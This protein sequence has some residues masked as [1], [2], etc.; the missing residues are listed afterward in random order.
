VKV[1]P[2]TKVTCLPAHRDVDGTFPDQTV[3]FNMSMGNS[4]RWRR[5]GLINLAKMRS[6]ISAAAEDLNVIPR[7][8]DAVITTLSGGNQQKALLG[9]VVAD[10][11]GC[12]VLCEPT[13]GVDV[14]TRREIYAFVKKLA[15]D[16]CAV[17]V[18][19]SDMEDLAS[20]AD[21]IV[22]ISDEG[23]VESWVDAEG[24]AEFCS[25]RAALG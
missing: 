18:A 6:A 9:R 21:R 22:V 16:G 12:V 2:G 14:A 25:V 23:E 17:M 13:R 3:E 15:E 19:S 11:P 7:N 24:I 4:N 8:T 10:E 20:L 5:V 1:R